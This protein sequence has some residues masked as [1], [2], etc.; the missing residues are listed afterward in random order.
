MIY[1]EFEKVVNEQLKRCTDTMLKKSAE[2]STEEDKLHNFKCAG[3]LIGST[4]QEA[5][6]GMW[7]K[8]I[9]SITDMCRTGKDYPLDTWNEKIG[10]A[11]NY[12]LLLRAIVEE[13]KTNK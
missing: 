13:Q 9:V 10:D 11:I 12:L 4:P 7:I 1:K 8:H 6:C 2:Y 5:L 3:G